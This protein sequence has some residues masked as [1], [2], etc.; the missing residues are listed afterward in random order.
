MG[1]MYCGSLYGGLASLL[2]SVSPED[3]VIVIPDHSLT[4]E[5]PY[6]LMVLV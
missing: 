6:F 2:S 5:L 3:L 4:N 1:N